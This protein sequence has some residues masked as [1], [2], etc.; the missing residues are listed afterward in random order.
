MARVNCSERIVSPNLLYTPTY[1]ISPTCQTYSTRPSIPSHQHVKLTL[2][3]HL[4]HLTNMS[5]L[6]YTSI[7]SISPTCQTYSTRPSI[8]SHQ[9]AQHIL[10]TP[11]YSIS[12][13]CQTYSTRPSIPSHQHAQHTLHVHFFLPHQ[14]AKFSLKRTT[15][16]LTATF[17]SLMT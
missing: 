10:Y 3:A 5:N 9:H 16:C 11:I 6:L 14:Q 2:H 12:P 8:P 17:L 1:S 4:F 15:Q 13:T 7:Y